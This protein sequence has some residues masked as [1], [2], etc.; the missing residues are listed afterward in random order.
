MSYKKGQLLR[1][2]NII[3]LDIEKEQHQVAL[4]D[5]TTGIDDINSF[6]EFCVDKKDG[7]EYTTKPEKLMT[8]SARYK[9][10]QADSKVPLDVAKT[11]SD[12]ITDKVKN[13]RTFI[14]DS[15]TKF[16][17][18]VVDGHHYF[19]PKELRALATLGSTMHII[20]L[21]KI[22]E[23]KDE[24]MK[25]FIEKFT[26]PKRYEVLTNNQKRVSALIGGVK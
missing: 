25:K 12:R 6:L 9:K 1:L 23:L 17:N 20:E 26:D 18:L 10:L 8:L 7:I 22:G 19:E 14:E 13:C 2:A 4:Y 16:L 11:F 15:D 21:S 3:G 24:L 5:A